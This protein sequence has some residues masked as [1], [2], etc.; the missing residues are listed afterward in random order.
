M[1]GL[2]FSS[3]S[4]KALYGYTDANQASNINDH[5]LI[6]GYCVY[7]GNNLV[8]WFSKKQMLWLSPVQNRALANGAAEIVWIQAFLQELGV[9]L[10][11]LHV[12]CCDNMSASS[13]VANPTFHA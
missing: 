8:S 3:P 11:T 13:L 1:L 10:T 6:R 12:L 2:Q 4:H 7:Y 9:K 5:C